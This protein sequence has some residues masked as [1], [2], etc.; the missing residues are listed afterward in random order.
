MHIIHLIF[1]G[2][3]W[4]QCFILKLVARIF[5]WCICIFATVWHF[6]LHSKM[7][8]SVTYVHINTQG[9]IIYKYQLVK[10]FNY[11]TITWQFYSRALWQLNILDRNHQSTDLQ[12]LK[13]WII[14]YIVII[15]AYHQYNH[16]YF[17]KSK[18]NH[19]VD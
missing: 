1:I 4:I 8:F 10:H 18:K 11:L 12:D 13:Y 14:F 16:H 7:Y 5:N 15:I 6:F 19:E 9:E 3:S 17:N 2:D